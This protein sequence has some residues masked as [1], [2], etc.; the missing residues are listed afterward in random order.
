MKETTMNHV[1]NEEE[2]E[3]EVDEKD[4]NGGKGRRKT[5]TEHNYRGYFT[6]YEN[7]YSFIVDLREWEGDRWNSKFSWVPFWCMERILR[8]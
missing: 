7:E 6:I 3:R 1:G 5:L 8:V 4:G 2:N